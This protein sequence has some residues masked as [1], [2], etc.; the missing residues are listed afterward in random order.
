MNPRE[1]M[2]RISDRFNADGEFSYA[3]MPTA[4]CDQTTA[5]VYK[6]RSSGHVTAALLPNPHLHGGADRM[7]VRLTPSGQELLE[8]IRNA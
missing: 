7:V 6:L 2:Q 1:V 4:S 8:D 5:E 3:W